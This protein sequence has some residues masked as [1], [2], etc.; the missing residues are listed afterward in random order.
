MTGITFHLLYSWLP[1]FIAKT[2]E[3]IEN[4]LHFIGFNFLTA[5]EIGGT[6]T[7]TQPGLK[8]RAK[9]S[10]HT[11]TIAKTDLLFTLV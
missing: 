8:N 3:I 6:A 9:L 11:I 4:N 1:L 2:F 7:M 5:N 10:L